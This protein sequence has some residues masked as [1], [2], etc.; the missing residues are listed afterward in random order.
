MCN[1]IEEDL[2]DDTNGPDIDFVGMSLP[3]QDFRGDVVGRA[4]NSFLLLLRVLQ[5]GGK[6]EISQLDLHILIE[7]QISQFQ[8][9]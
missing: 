2:H 8:A 3:L 6:A 4:T 9:K 7:E 5:S 1:C